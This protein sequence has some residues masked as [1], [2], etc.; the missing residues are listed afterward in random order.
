MKPYEIFPKDKRNKLMS[1]RDYDD[2]TIEVLE[3]LWEI[4]EDI[5]GDVGV[6]QFC[7]VEIEVVSP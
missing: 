1:W 6:M 7:R 4:T 3:E 5:R 2:S